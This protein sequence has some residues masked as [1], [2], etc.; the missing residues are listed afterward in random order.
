MEQ[1]KTQPEYYESVLS[2][3]SSDVR[4]RMEDQLEKHYADL[5]ETSGI[6]RLRLLKDINFLEQSLEWQGANPKIVPFKELREH[7]RAPRSEDAVD[8]KYQARISN[9]AT[10]IRA[11][12]VQCQGG[13]VIGVKECPSAT[14]PLFP[15]RMGKDP[16]RGFDLP[17]AAPI[18]I[19]DDET[20]DQFEE[21]DD[22]EEADATE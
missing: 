20:D 2:P 19:E 17:K 9:R 8:N 1:A 16:L 12:C 18:I 5:P 11:Y 14:C 7:I 10:G 4:A 22:A 13:S 3:E 6:A 21:G 15:F